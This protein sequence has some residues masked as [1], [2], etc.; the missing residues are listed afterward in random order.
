M[1]KH[2]AVTIVSKNYFAYAKTLAES[3][4]SHHPE[5]DFIIVLVDKADGYVPASL[6]CGAE[7]VELGDV[8]IPDISRFIYRYSI[9]ELNTAVK[10]FALADFFQKR[11]YETLLY[12][13]PDILVF[14]PLT[15]I[16]EALE[17]A[18]IVL[19]PHM[20]KP[21]YDDAMPSDVSILQSG[22][23]NL[24]FI[25]LKNSSSATQLLD[26]WMTKLYR[27]CIVDIPNG[28]FVDQKWMDLVPGF[29]PD[30]KIIYDPGYNAAYWNLHERTLTHS[31]DGWRVDGE[32]LSFFHFSGYIPF[33]PQSLSKHQN[34]HRLENLPVLKMLTDQYASALFEAGY[35]QSSSWPYAFE[36]LSNGVPMPMGIVRN[37]MQW[38]ARANVPTPCP[39][40][41]A[42]GFCRFLMSRNQ[43]PNRPNA[44]LLFEFL[45]KMRGDVTAT[46]SGAL[47][48][49]DDAAFRGWVSDSGV[50]EYGFE[51][52]LAFETEE[53]ADHVADTFARLRKAN[54]RDVLDKH[55]GMWS[56]PK[57]FEAFANWISAHGVKQLKLTRKHADMLRA[58][59][60]GVGRILNIYFLRGDLQIHFPVIWDAAQIGAFS[61]WL[62]QHR[63]ELG[64]SLDDIS[65]FIEFAASENKLI[66]KMRFLY[67][68]KG[69]LSRA[70][71][72]IYAIDA[73][74]YEISS[75]LSTAEVLSFL[76]DEAEIKPVDHY[77]EK[78]GDSV[79][80]LDDFEK[81]A[82]PGLSPK[83]NYAYF[84]RL[85]AE[86]G[87]REALRPLVNCAGYF[88]AESGMGESG[89]SMRA[90]LAATGLANTLMSLPHPKALLDSLPSKAELFGWPS[91]GADVAVAVANA[92]STGLLEAFM[93]ASFW[94]KKNVGYWVWETEE[95][96]AKYKKCEALF[97]E[98]WTPSRYSA[99]AIARTVSVPVRVLPHTLDFTAIEHAK[100]NR[101]K[102]GLPEN[103]TL[104]GFMFDPL[105]VIERKNVGGLI[106]AFGQAFRQDDNCFLVLKVNGRTQG[107]YDYEMIRA[108]AEGERVLFIEATLSRIDTFDFLKSLDVYVSLHRAEGFGLTCAEAMALGVP[109]IASE[110]SGNLEFMNRENSLLVPCNV[111]ETERAFGAYPSGT[112]WADPDVGAASAMMRSLLAA[113]L[114]REFAERGRA[115]IS[116]ELAPVRIAGIART[117]F[118]E[119]LDR[120]MQ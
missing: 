97:D 60:G 17:S 33:A 52:L 29:F 48:D 72:S 5:N 82:I 36:T 69:L 34:R 11:N 83:K 51:K 39:V 18:S 9:M 71:P 61:A 45:L 30:H 67:T 73:R 109:V 12:I 114:R 6:P 106:K 87:E 99:E 38:A 93:P 25:G 101:R 85:K 2:A 84:L 65:L 43:L 55:A 88:N 86:V 104:F 47:H 16:Y 81:S 8:A 96:P 20:R 10:P 100:P 116:S 94:G 44:V 107:A 89:R 21:Y 78:F 103:A 92:D 66:D 113:P 75:V 42:D 119:L 58:S 70:T 4:K 46:Y 77:V 54:R 3:Y 62:R 57:V 110:Y 32:P 105:S 22:T 31:A 19:T 50:R 79:S 63:N 112:R 37:I 35:E 102:F 1:S 91:S 90:T 76:S 7:I 56:D 74:R 115:A 117:M 27:D 40:G 26:W 49:H 28:L 14:R 15:A 95:L 24:G 59:C 98:I 23:Y 111:I 118:S 80:Q 64:L 13:D 68:H 120:R 41:D 108:A 53:V